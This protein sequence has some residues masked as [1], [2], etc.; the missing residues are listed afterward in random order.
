[1]DRVAYADVLAQR[2]RYW[3]AFSDPS[4]RDAFEKGLASIYQSGEIDRII[5]SYHD[6]YGTSRDLY[7]E[8]DCRFAKL[9]PRPKCPAGK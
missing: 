3:Y 5:G 6:R 2:M 9:S 8:L 7:I 4:V 1:M